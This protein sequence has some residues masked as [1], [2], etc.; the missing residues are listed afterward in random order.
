MWPQLSAK[1]HQNQPC[2]QTRTRHLKAAPGGLGPR[3]RGLWTPSLLSHPDPC[4]RRT[5]QGRRSCLG[6]SSLLQAGTLYWGPRPRESP[7]PPSPAPTTAGHSAHI[8]SQN[9]LPLL[10]GH[11]APAP[12]PPSHPT[13]RRER[14]MGD[15]ETG[16]GQRAHSRKAQD[17]ASPR[18]QRAEWAELRAQARRAKRRAGPAP[19]R[20]A[21]ERLGGSLRCGKAGPAGRKWRDRV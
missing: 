6:V 19:P 20:W 10:M 15:A 1:C 2:T 14:I 21:G 8:V 5:S 16:E 13:S 7:L 11:L 9:L 4:P 18:A 12:H 17:A 3:P